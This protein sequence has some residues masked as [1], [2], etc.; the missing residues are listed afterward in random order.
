MWCEVLLFVKYD[1]N[2]RND[3]HDVGSKTKK[4][5]ST[6]TFWV[7]FFIKHQQS[8]DM[9]KGLMRGVDRVFDPVLKDFCQYASGGL[10]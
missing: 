3:N 4:T 7:C 9:R 5:E 2:R 1:L 8:L 6:Q 10:L